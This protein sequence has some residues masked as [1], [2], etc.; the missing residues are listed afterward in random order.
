MARILIMDDNRSTSAL[1][2]K[3]LEREDHQVVIS[4]SWQEVSKNIEDPTIDL[5]LIHQDDSEWTT[6]N[7][8]KSDHQD[9][10]AMLYI[11]RDYSLTN[12]VW[13]V[14]AV[15][16]ALEQ[17][18]KLNDMPTLWSWDTDCRDSG[19]SYFVP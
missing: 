2:K 12:M 14:R 4:G 7:R 19:F 8:F 10:P 13:I 11:I 9:I 1:L 16:N 6:F 15:Q 18:N 5:V 3:A 17:L